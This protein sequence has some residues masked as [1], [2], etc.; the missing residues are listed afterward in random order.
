MPSERPVLITYYTSSFQSLADITVPRMEAYADRHG[1]DLHVQNLE[2][3]ETINTRMWMKI[4][5]ML[6]HAPRPVIWMDTDCLIIDLDYDFS[7]DR[8]V[9][10]ARDGHGLCAC[11]LSIGNEDGW[12]LIQIMNTLGDMANSVKHEQQVLRHLIDHFPSVARKVVVDITVSDPEGMRGRA[13]VYHGW[14]TA[15]NYAQALEKMRSIAGS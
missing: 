13:P 4:A 15:C 5:F 7:T 3:G 12:E 11:V 2:A 6:E 14:A 8:A 1:M 10:T 9:R